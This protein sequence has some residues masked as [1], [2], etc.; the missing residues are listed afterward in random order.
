[1]SYVLIT[2]ALLFSDYASLR[3]ESLIEFQKGHYPQA[4]VLVRTAIEAT[5]SAHD[6]YA[7]ALNYATLGD[8]L[9]TQLRFSEAE[10][11]YRKALLILNGD[12]THTHAAAIVW[13]NF[14]G[15]LTGDAQFREAISALKQASKLLA[16]SKVDDPN[17]S[18]QIQ[19]GLGVIQFQ[20]GDFNKAEASFARAAGFPIKPGGPNDAGLWQIM[21]NLGKAYEAKHEYQKAEDA[22]NRSLQ[23]AR[24]QLGE[25]N[26]EMAILHGNLGGLYGETG[27]FEEAEYQFLRSLGI[28]QLRAT[29]FD[30]LALMHTLYAFARSCVA[31][32]NET[33]AEPMLARA[34]AIARKQVSLGEMPEVSEIFELYSKVLMDLSNASEAEQVRAEARRVRAA[35]AFTVPVRTL[36]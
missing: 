34:A 27:R 33:R 14:S 15:A 9:E 10:R 4:E 5:K 36:R 17:L 8:I 19:N 26:A 21:N 24:V 1:M 20:Q 30:D 7:E 12:T 23:L 25:A 11:E 28:L 32:K 18:A 22:F 6:P 16:A 35:M 31:Q 13:R 29:P 3:Q 2:I